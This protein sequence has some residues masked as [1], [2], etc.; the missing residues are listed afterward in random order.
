[1]KRNEKGFTAWERSTEV[2][3]LIFGTL[4]FLCGIGEMIR[5]AMVYL[6]LDLPNAIAGIWVLVI[7]GVA[8]LLPPLSAWII[9]VGITSVIQAALKCYLAGKKFLAFLLVSLG[10]TGCAF[11]T[12]CYCLLFISYFPRLGSF[13]GQPVTLLFTYGAALGLWS[14][15]IATLMGSSAFLT[16]GLAVLLAHVS[17][18]VMLTARADPISA[19]LV[20]MTIGSMFVIPIVLSN[21]EGEKYEPMG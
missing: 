21:M 9:A 16:Q 14:L 1:M 11:F 5:L 8:L 17:F 19:F 12:A 15:G 18:V 2:S 6:R 13:L 7:I 10:V 3:L 20:V 4:S